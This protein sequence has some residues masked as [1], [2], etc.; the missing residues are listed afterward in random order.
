MSPFD[1]R[2]RYAIAVDV[3]VADQTPA[4][5]ASNGIYVGGAGVLVCVLKNGKSPTTFT[6]LLAGVIYNFQ[7]VT[8]V[9]T[10]TTITNS[11]LLY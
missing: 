10:N 11:Q 8:V 3:S 9:K 6:G 5:G 7:V 4:D 1:G 2:H